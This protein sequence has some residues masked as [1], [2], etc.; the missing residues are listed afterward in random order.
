MGNFN[1]YQI[2]TNNIQ[3]GGF[4]TNNFRDLQANIQNLVKNSHATSTETLDFNNSS[5]SEI[6]FDTIRELQQ[7]GGS[8]DYLTVKPTKKRYEEPDLTFLKPQ[9][10]K[11]GSLTPKNTNNLTSEA[12]DSDIKFV[13]ELINNYSKQEGGCGCGVQTN[14]FSETSD[15]SPQ[16][17]VINQPNSSN[18]LNAPSK[19]TD[20]NLPTDYNILKGGVKKNKHSSDDDED[21]STE[22]DEYDTEDEDEDDD[23][24][25]DDD[26]EDD[27]D[28]DDE[29]E[30][31]ETDDED[32]M[33]RQINKSSTSTSSS[34]DTSNFS[35]KEILARNLQRKNKNNKKDNKNSSS[36]SGGSESEIVINTKYLYSSSNNFSG[37]DSSE[38]YGHF[39][40]RT[41][42]K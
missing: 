34:S 40:N 10:T 12:N 25:D 23:D 41:M 22:S 35:R 24:D 30:D 42:L 18:S 29:T 17:V 38:Y 36:Q 14:V 13:E 19:P 15:V 9:F 6:D 3:S 26:D 7:N 8:L 11:G 21:F 27:D 16:P 1:S 31:D 32:K 4:Y 37:S 20:Q 39:R 33:G 5:L 2:D 28:D